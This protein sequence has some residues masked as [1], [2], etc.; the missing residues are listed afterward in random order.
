MEKIEKEGFWLNGR[1]LKL[2]GFG[3]Y[4]SWP[5]VG[6][7]MPREIVKK[8][9]TYYNEDSAFERNGIHTQEKA[10][11]ESGSEESN[12][13]SYEQKMATMLDLVSRGESML[14]MVQRYFWDKDMSSYRVS[15][16]EFT[17]RHYLRSLI[18]K[19]CEALK[20]QILA[21]EV[22]DFLHAIPFSE[23]NVFIYTCKLN[24]RK[25]FG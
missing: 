16:V 15:G 18:D 22:Y 21:K 3:R 4:Q 1:I 8:E 14:A 12:Q 5:Y 11:F 25:S 17:I 19:L 20:D 2:C 24:K 7:A 13:Y 6:Y 23:S 9:L 10:F